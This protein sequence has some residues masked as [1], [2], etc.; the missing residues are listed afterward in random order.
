MELLAETNRHGVLKLRAAHLDDGVELIGLLEQCLFEALQLNL[1]AAE[2]RESRHFA[3]GRE[4]VVGRLAEVH[5]VI[6]VH[7]AVIALGAAENFDGAVCDDLI[8]I[9]VERGTGAA[10]NRV[11]NEL[12]VQLA[13]DDFVAGFDDCACALLREL[14]DLKVRDRS[15]LLDLGNADNE[16]RMHLEPGDVEIL[17][18]AE[19]L[20][21]VIG[22][23]RDFFFT[24]RIVLQA[25]PFS[26]FR[27]GK[28]SLNRF[29]EVLV[30]SL[31]ERYT[32]HKYQ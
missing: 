24:D 4:H 26:Y 20:H 13:V 11:D 25:I 8:G 18:R 9:H 2:Q 21:A 27:H 31:T 32:I 28:T 1:R 15:G 3:A 6:R 7:N 22:V 29:F 5:M 19:R 12:I 30:S 16:L 17:M 23:N 14:A 10:L